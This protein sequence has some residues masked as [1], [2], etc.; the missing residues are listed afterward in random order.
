M[1]RSYPSVVR[2]LL[3]RPSL[4]LP[5]ALTNLAAADDQHYDVDLKL[6][7]RRGI[8]KDVYKCTTP[9]SDYQFRPNFAIAMV[10]ASELFDP[11]HALNCLQL[12]DGVLRGPTGMC[13]LD[14]SDI[15]YRPNYVNSDDSDNF[16]TAKGR[17]YHQGPEWLWCTGFFL[18]A[19]LK[20]DLARRKDKAGMVETLQQLH[21][22]LYYHRRKIRDSPWAGLVELTNKD[23]GS[24]L[25]HS[26]NIQRNVMMLA[27]VKLGVR[28]LYLVLSARVI[29]NASD[30]MHDTS[31]LK[32]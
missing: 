1:E 31:L 27:I 18:R 11:V 20:F 29:T 24:T 4:Y 28:A 26:S 17:N 23:G 25:C 16:E 6:V 10:V 30:L 5:I 15:H 3:L 12:A 9:W 8:Y 2:T 22:R 14:P 13:T 7:N 19:F 32:I 21:S